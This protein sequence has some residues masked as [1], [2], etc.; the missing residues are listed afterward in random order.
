MSIERSAEVKHTVVVSYMVISDTIEP[1]PNNVFNL[2]FFMFKEGQ[3]PSP[4]KSKE[5]QPEDLQDD[6][7]GRWSNNFS[8]LLI[9]SH[10][11]EKFGLNS[12]ETTGKLS[13]KNALCSH[14]GIKGL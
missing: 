10:F 5:E 2:Y 1:F 13:V 11:E 14:L 9:N 6:A 4:T 3:P 8:G 12:W 7:E